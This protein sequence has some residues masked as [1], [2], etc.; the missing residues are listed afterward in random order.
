MTSGKCQ[1]PRTCTCPS[2]NRYI[3]AQYF[4][5]EIG[6]VIKYVLRVDHGDEVGHFLGVEGGHGAEVTHVA[7][8]RSNKNPCTISKKI[9]SFIGAD[10]ELLE[11]LKLIKIDFT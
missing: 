2:S 6:I 4:K 1:T 11:V 7:K 3:H 5:V 9:I 10:S 8:V